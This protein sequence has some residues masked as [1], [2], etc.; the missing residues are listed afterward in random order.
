MD[1]QNK[2]SLSEAFELLKEMRTVDKEKGLQRFMTEIA[3]DKSKPTHTMWYFI[4]NIAAILIPAFL[5]LNTYL[6]LTKT[7][8]SLFEQ[9]SHKMEIVA[10]NGTKVLYTLP[11]S[12]AVW[13]RGGSKLIYED[14]MASSKERRVILDGEAYFKVKSDAERPFYVAMNDIDIKVTGTEFNCSTDYRNQ[15]R[16]TLAKGHVD[17]LKKRTDGKLFLTS[18]TP[19]EHFNYDVKKQSYSV[20]DVDVRKYIGWKDG[21][22]LFDNDPMT[23][24]IEQISHWYGVNIVMADPAIGQIRF[25]AHFEDLKLNQIIDI[26]ELSSNLTSTYIRGKVD[27]KGNAI[28][29]KLILRLK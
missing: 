15:I 4:R 28:Q 12:T 3:A 17:M 7:N 25:T 11:D 16:V 18:L 10:M 5:A 14:N 1:I 29:D 13:L 8:E 23:D 26:L 24:V 20:K 6:L 27:E 22:L 9:K 21:F 19:G 2:D